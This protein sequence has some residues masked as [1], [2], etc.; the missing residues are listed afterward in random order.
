MKITSNRNLK[1]LTVCLLFPTS[2]QLPFPGWIFS[3][4][5]PWISVF[6]LLSLLCFICQRFQLVWLSAV[7]T[8]QNLNQNA[9]KCQ[10]MHLKK[11][12]KKK[13][14]RSMY[15]SNIVIL[16][17]WKL[18]GLKVSFLILKRFCFV[19]LQTKHATISFIR[20]IWKL[21]WKQLDWAVLCCKTSPFPRQRQSHSWT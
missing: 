18:Q 5:Y 16:L 4:G 2:S 11:K 15:V 9:K 8:G 19:L 12:K 6:S 3:Q 10:Y 7:L 1:S 20:L 21:S 13:D 17:K 14:L